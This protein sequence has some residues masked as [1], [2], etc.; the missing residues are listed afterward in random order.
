MSSVMG[1]TFE[2]CD[3]LEYKNVIYYDHDFFG[4]IDVLVDHPL[5]HTIVIDCKSHYKY[6]LYI[7][8]KLTSDMTKYIDQGYCP[9]QTSGW[10]FKN[11]D[12]LDDVFSEISSIIQVNI[13][14]YNKQ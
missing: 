7:Y 2:I 13:K 11:I 9:Y 12:K 1:R 6:S 3:W 14:K 4:R 5:I 10:I 8:P